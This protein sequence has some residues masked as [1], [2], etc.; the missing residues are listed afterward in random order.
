MPNQT[1]HEKAF[2]FACL[3]GLENIISTAVKA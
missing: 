3:K 1:E 2:E